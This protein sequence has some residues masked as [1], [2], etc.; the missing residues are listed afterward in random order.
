MSSES[1]LMSLLE[2]TIKDLVNA[3]VDE[4]L[5]GSQSQSPQP[6]LSADEVGVRLGNIDKQAVYRLVRENKLKVVYL[7]ETRF[8]IHPDEVDRFI[9]EGGVKPC[10]LVE[11]PRIV[12]RGGSRQ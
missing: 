5:G 12:S 9:R 3:V 4:R 1:P 11:S 8:K 10:R 6:L 7:S 2:Q